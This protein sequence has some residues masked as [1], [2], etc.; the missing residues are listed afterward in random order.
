MP[1]YESVLIV[2]NHFQSCW[3]LSESA[4]FRL[5]IEKYAKTLARTFKHCTCDGTI[6]ARIEGVADIELCE[7]WNKVF[8]RTLYGFHV[9]AKEKRHT[10]AG[11]VMAIFCKEFFFFEQSLWRETQ[12]FDYASPLLLGT[13]FYQGW[14]K[15]PIST[16]QCLA[17]SE[18]STSF[19]Y[20]SLS[21]YGQSQFFKVFIFVSHIYF[22]FHKLV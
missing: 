17:A 4:F 9:K 5:D 19:T 10:H 3:I 14:P 18:I 15:G 1:V 16:Q 12:N 6:T 22:R 8:F 2:H 20:F 21:T 11:Q 7:F 13:A